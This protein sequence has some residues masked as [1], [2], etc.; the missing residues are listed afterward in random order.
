MLSPKSPC[1]SHCRSVTESPQASTRPSKTS[2]PLMVLCQG[3]LVFPWVR[4]A[5]PLPHPLG[6]GPIPSLFRNPSLC[7]LPL[8]RVWFPWYALPARNTGSL[9]LPTLPRWQPRTTL[10]LVLSTLPAFG[11]YLP[12][13]RRTGRG[14]FTSLWQEA[15]VPHGHPSRK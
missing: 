9:P 5:A 12:L 2:R 14:C 15:S 11:W 8:K 3:V 7:Q 6:T 1:F 13:S 10:P 4:R